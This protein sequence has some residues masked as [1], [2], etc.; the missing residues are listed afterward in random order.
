MLSQLHKMGSPFANHAPNAKLCPGLAASLTLLLCV[1]V[2]LRAAHFPPSIISQPT[3]QTV[4][5][6]QSATFAVSASGTAPLAYQWRLN[7]TNLPGGTSTN[8]LVTSVN[9]S[10]A[11]LY[12]VQVTN[13]YGAPIS[14]N[15]TLTV[16][17][18]PA[19][20]AQPI[21]QTALLGSNTTFVVT[22]AGTPPFSYRWQFSAADMAGATNSTLDISD[23]QS[24]KLGA[25]RAIVTNPYGAITSSPATLTL[26]TPPGFLWVRNVTNG[27]SPNYAAI[28]S[29]THIAADN[30]GNVFAAGTFYGISPASIEFGGGAL[31]NNAEGFVSAYFICKYDRFGNF[32]WARQVATNSSGGLPLRLATDSAGN[33]YFVGRFDGSATFGTN[34]LVSSSTANLF[35]AKY[36]SQGQALWAR[37]IGA[38]DSSSGALGPV[39]ALAVDSNANA[40]VSSRY[41]D[42]ANFGSTAISNSDAFLA[43]YDSVGNL[44]WAKPSLAV[45][46]IAAGLSGSVYVTG[47]SLLSTAPGL[48]AKY[49]PVG[50]VVWSRQFPQG[51]SIA[52]DPAENI[53]TTG[54][55][56][57]TY[58]DITITNTAYSHF[59]I[60]RCGS[61]G[62]LK[63]VREA[64][65]VS[66]EVGLG[67]AVDAFGNIYATAVS[68]NA[69][70]EPVF[71]FGSTTLS[72]AYSFLA[73]YDP[74]G[75]ALWAVAPGGTNYAPPYAMSL[76]NHQEIYLAGKFYYKAT[77]GKSSLI[78]SNPMGPGDFYVAKFAADTTAVITLG[79]PQWIAGGSQIQF[80]VTGVPG[81]KYAIEASTNLI[82]WVSLQTNTAPFLFVAPATSA[83]QQRYYRSILI[84]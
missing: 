40:F 13:L 73:K 7:G 18:P 61:S 5:V 32:D 37:Q 35:L 6:G 74:G 4:V 64:G 52:V 12:S 76:V 59:F 46:A 44:V 77:F 51:K 81:F 70:R 25:Y 17:L 9:W 63:W 53:Y 11:G 62:Q 45:N 10:D 26:A 49:D 2:S 24:N 31:T 79:S 8:L 29:A 78:D 54:W 42:T 71:T 39:L 38:Y 41:A 33:V 72:N 15:A 84:P 66:Q 14:S 20:S 80:N 60:A 3:N 50:S 19:I 82:Y 48:L 68:A 34:T 55:G 36:D 57:G 28:S 27:V 65:S 21:S 83:F 58:G 1:P 43:K 16:A 75:N 47:S 56:S 67:V 22:A 23:V 69:Q 30:A